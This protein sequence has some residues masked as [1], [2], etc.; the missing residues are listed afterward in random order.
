MQL[1]NFCKNVA[2]AK[3]S[4]KECVGK[5]MSLSTNTDSNY[6]KVNAYGLQLSIW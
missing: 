1:S 4:A 3:L 5:P 2:M 6:V